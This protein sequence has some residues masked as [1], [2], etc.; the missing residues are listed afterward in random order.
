LKIDNSVE[1][2]PSIG[3]FSTKI[4]GIFKY[5]KLARKCDVIYSWWLTSYFPVLLGL[6]TNKK[7][8]LIGGGFD[9][10]KFPKINYGAFTNKTKTMIVNFSARFTS[11]I[12]FVSNNIKHEFMKNSKVRNN[13]S[14]V[15]LGF[16]SKEWYHLKD[17][18]KVYDYITVTINS[19]GKNSKNRHLIKGID[20]FIKH[21][22][23]N[24]RKKYLLIGC[25]YK[26][27]RSLENQV[28]KNI[29]SKPYSTSKELLIYYNQSRA[30]IQS[31]RFESFGCTPIEAMLC[32]CKVI[33]FNQTGILSEKGIKIEDLTFENRRLK[34]N[35][36]INKLVNK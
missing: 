20:L 27:L 22:I 32:G 13:C 9:C 36:I 33:L 5:I 26:L 15:N 10:G 11:H 7:V 30:Y 8:V 14:V 25:T 31:S 29:T 3:V 24:P 21:A 16:N 34:L 28:P 2:L 6:I 18:K 4:F 19:F 17:T 35:K 1:L 23:K 12:I